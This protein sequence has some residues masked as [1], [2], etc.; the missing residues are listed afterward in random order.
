MDEKQKKVLNKF[1]KN[2][3][4]IKYKKGEVI[5]KP[6]QEFTGIA[7]VKSGYAKMYTKSKSGKLLTLPIFKPIFF[8]SMIT[9]MMKKK[10]EHYIEAIT[11]V[12]IWIA[13]TEKTL[14]FLKAEKDLFKEMTLF[15][16]KE[17]MSL[18]CNI[19]QFVF[20]DATIKV[21]NILYSIAD[22]YGTKTDNGI[23]IKFKTPHK[24]L[25]SML[26]LTRETVTLQILKME[27]GKIL[28]K[29]GRRL[30]VKNMD[31]LKDLGT[32]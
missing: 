26:G 31:K 29:H 6:G 30:V 4:L 27:K 24:M 10:S 1:F 3:P 12:E 20:G 11:P 17:M 23:E 9:T 15:V 18:C 22:K 5:L 16:T 14:A 25:A 8:Y 13:P 7:F 32:L 21:A 28:A 2:Y 19:T